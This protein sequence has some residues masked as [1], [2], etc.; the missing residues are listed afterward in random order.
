MIIKSITEDSKL[1]KE[2]ILYMMETLTILNKAKE[3]FID[4]IKYNDIF[5]KMVLNSTS[6]LDKYEYKIQPTYFIFRKYIVSLAM[7]DVYSLGNDIKT[8]EFY[9]D[10]RYS[11]EDDKYDRVSYGL[12]ITIS[13]DGILILPYLDLMYMNLR[14][15]ILLSKFKIGIKDKDDYNFYKIYTVIYNM[16]KK[17]M[18]EEYPDVYENINK[19]DDNSEY[20]IKEIAILTTLVY[21]KYVVPAK[22]YIKFMDLEKDLKDDTDPT[23]SIYDISR[24]LFDIGTK[25]PK[26]LDDTIFKIRD[27]INK[28]AK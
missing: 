3:E 23:K 2:M 18:L 1:Y 22:E 9:T 27:I 11:Y 15:R 7:V 16:T 24:S 26:L 19:I 14:S 21:M 12:D 10:I 20:L 5:Q 8:I 28:V 25:D 6:C 17:S 13:K 4:P